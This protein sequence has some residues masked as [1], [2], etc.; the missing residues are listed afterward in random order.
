MEAVLTVLGFA[1]LP[2]IALYGYIDRY[3]LRRRSLRAGLAAFEE[4][5]RPSGCAVD[6]ASCYP[7][8]E[9]MVKELAASRGLRYTGRAPGHR[10]LGPMGFAPDR[11]G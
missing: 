8:S 7:L 1:V 6:V 10:R 2:A 3:R 11:A 5:Y 9:H 4:Q